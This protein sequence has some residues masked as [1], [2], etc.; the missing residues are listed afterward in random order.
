MSS[1]WTRPGSYSFFALRRVSALFCV[2]KLF[3]LSSAFHTLHFAALQK[4]Q[5]NAEHRSKTQNSVFSVDKRIR[6][7][8][9]L[10]VI[11]VCSTPEVCQRHANV[12]HFQKWRW[13]SLPVWS[14]SETLTAE[15]AVADAEVERAVRLGRHDLRALLHRREAQLQ[16]R[17]KATNGVR[18]NLNTCAQNSTRAKLY[19]IRFHR[20]GAGL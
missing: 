6:P 15:V 11:L 2:Q 5:R 16:L 18:R 17:T 9:Q 4:M 20:R 19:F 3:F 8:C 12:R 1:S 7:R 14:W 13:R 10:T